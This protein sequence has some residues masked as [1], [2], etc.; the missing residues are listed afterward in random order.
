MCPS[1]LSDEPI[2]WPFLCLCAYDFAAADDD[3]ESNNYNDLRKVSS[4]RS[5]SPSHAN[6]SPRKPPRTA[7]APQPSAAGRHRRG[8]GCWCFDRQLTRTNT[9]AE[10]SKRPAPVG[11]CGRCKVTGLFIEG[12]SELVLSRPVFSR[13]NCKKWAHFASK[14]DYIQGLAQAWPE[15]EQHHRALAT[16]A[17][18]CK[19]M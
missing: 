1:S 13:E 15:T 14:F 7:E 2:N 18:L 9:R 16:E 8:L 17:S 5:S 4:P 6:G 12:P 3:D 19:L 11:G 10:G